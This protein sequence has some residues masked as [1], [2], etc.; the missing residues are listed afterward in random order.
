MAGMQAK[1]AAA[2]VAQGPEV[3]AIGWVVCKVKHLA[4]PASTVY[5]AKSDGKHS[6]DLG[7]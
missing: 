6:A 4:L 1:Q 2:K 5:P 3:T 7:P